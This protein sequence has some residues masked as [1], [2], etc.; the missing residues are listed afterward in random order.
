[1]GLGGEDLEAGGEGEGTTLP[2]VP[3]GASV[4]NILTKL[5]SKPPQTVVATTIRITPTMLETLK[6]QNHTQKVKE[7]ASELWSIGAFGN[8]K[9]DEQLWFLL[10]E[11]VIKRNNKV[12]EEIIS[13]IAK[14]LDSLTLPFCDRDLHLIESFKKLSKEL[15]Q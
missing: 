5:A 6:D 8:Y 7:I 2:N 15:K 11:D 3:V 10:A 4:K 14:I 13:K 12:R 9:E 1:M